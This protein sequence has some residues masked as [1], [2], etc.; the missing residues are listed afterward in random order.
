MS[1]GDQ[2]NENGPGIRFRQRG[3]KGRPTFEKKPLESDWNLQRLDLG[4]FFTMLPR[5]SG[6]YIIG[7][8]LPSQE[9]AQPGHLGDS[10]FGIPS[11]TMSLSRV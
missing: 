2:G 10:F 1:F 6:F 7:M 5:L 8:P 4:K 9:R 11:S 3:Y